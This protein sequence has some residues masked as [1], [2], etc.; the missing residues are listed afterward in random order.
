MRINPGIIFAGVTLLMPVAVYPESTGIERVVDK[1]VEG[2][3]QGGFTELERQTIHAY[4]GDRKPRDS[5]YE[6][7]HRDDRYDESNK[8][9]EY[10]GK[11]DK[12]EKKHKKMPPGLAKR[13]QLPPGLQ[14]QY[15]RNGRL[16]PG[17]EKHGLPADL[18]DSLPDTHRGL[19]RVIVDADVLLVESAT[20]IV[21][22]I[23]YDIVK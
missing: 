12:K 22:D 8:H 3:I 15:E 18:E 9:K 19:Q 1:V 2:A 11:K 5:G 13:D 21:R 6:E 23:L 7:G 17:L 4:Y 20:W 16:P 10:K 14:R